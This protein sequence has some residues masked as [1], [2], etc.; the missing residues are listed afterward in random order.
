[1][2]RRQVWKRLERGFVSDIADA[3]G[4]ELEVPPNLPGKRVLIEVKGSA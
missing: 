3:Y 1:M 2:L 4:V